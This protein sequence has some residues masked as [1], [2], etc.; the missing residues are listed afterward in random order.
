MAGLWDSAN[1]PAIDGSPPF[2]ADT[3]TIVT[4][5]SNKQLNFLHGRMP[6]ILDNK[7][8]LELWLSNEPWGPSLEK[9]LRPYDKKLECYQVPPEVG[10]VQNDSPVRP[11]PE[12]RPPFSRLRFVQG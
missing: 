10:K 8:D 3:F 11:S 6:V 7:A 12:T 5:N 1:I 9:L 2:Q 4:T